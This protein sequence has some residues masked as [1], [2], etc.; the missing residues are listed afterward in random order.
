[1]WYIN[2]GKLARL[3]TQYEN[4]F[5]IILEGTAFLLQGV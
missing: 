4:L 2:R 3:I 5:S 1:M